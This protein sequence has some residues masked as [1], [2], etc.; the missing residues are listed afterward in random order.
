MTM[1]WLASGGR[2]RKSAGG[3]R[4]RK[5][6]S[7]RSSSKKKSAVVYSLYDS[8]GRRSYVGTTH[9][10][11]RRVGEHKKAGKLKRGGRLVVESGRMSRE[12]AERLEAKKIRGY[13]RRMGRLPKGNKTSDGQYHS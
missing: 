2:R 5:S 10:P 12:S 11:A 1:R 3:R 7:G 8:G 6:R 13:K 9:N 4:S